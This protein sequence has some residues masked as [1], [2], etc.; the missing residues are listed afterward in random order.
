MAIKYDPRTQVPG[1][2]I[3]PA[4]GTSCI[5]EHRIKGLEVNIIW[6]LVDLEVSSTGIATGNGY[7]FMERS[8]DLRPD[9]S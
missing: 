7:G 5:I 9:Q 1:N 3:D 6:I 8:L 2:L 4:Q